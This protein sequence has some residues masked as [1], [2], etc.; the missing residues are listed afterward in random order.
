[1]ICKECGKDKMFVMPK[2]KLCDKCYYKIT[3]KFPKSKYT[4]VT[5][6][7]HKLKL[8]MKGECYNCKNGT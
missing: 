4:S 1:M 2:K 6:C 8:G 7:K 3:G 5:T